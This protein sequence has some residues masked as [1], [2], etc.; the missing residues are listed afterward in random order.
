MKI[1]APPGRGLDIFVTAIMRIAKEQFRMSIMC[2]QLIQHR[3]DGILIRAMSRL[4][5][6]TGN[7]LHFIRFATGLTNLSLIPRT[8][9]AVIARVRI[10]GILHDIAAG[11]FLN[12]DTFFLDITLFF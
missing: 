5:F 11:F 2:L 6:H 7:Q 12:C 10:R 3:F 8:F 1:D 4:N 9:V